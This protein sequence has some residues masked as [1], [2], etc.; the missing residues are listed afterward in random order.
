MNQ[1][2]DVA[3]VSAARATS[4]QDKQNNRG[5]CD[6][7][8]EAELDAAFGGK[9][10]F[11]NFQGYRQRGSGCTVPT[12]GVEGQFILQAQ[13][14]ESFEAHRDTYQTYAGQSLAT[15][16]PVSVGVEGYLVNDAQ[17]IAIDD[18]GRAISVALQVF[19]FGGDPPVTKQES[20]QGVEII[21]RQALERL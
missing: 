2:E 6:L 16:T 3:A 8:T 17:I 13:T 15:M 10:S 4:A 5:D 12:V 9:L 19:V 11:G 14:K 7:L 20:A 18:Q 21:A 1:G